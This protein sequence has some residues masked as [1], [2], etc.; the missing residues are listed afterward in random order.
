LSSPL[1]EA[2]A[3]DGDRV[4]FANA[5][6]LVREGSSG[7]DREDQEDG[8][9]GGGDPDPP[10]AEPVSRRASGADRQPLGT[11]D[12]A[13]DRQLGVVCDNS[14]GTGCAGGVEVDQ[15]QIVVAPRE[16]TSL[17]ISTCHLP[18]LR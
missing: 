2:L 8:A 6:L 4:A 14:L 11:A 15:V 18:D 16:S 17:L 13:N 12:R 3:D 10:R 1:A 9:G 5:I 7:Q